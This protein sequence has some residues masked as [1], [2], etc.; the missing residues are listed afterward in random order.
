MVVKVWRRREMQPSGHDQRGH[1]A[2]IV[3]A[4]T[5]VGLGHGFAPA[6][7]LRKAASGLREMRDLS[8]FAILAADIERTFIAAR[9]SKIGWPP[10]NGQGKS[11][12]P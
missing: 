12:P 2:L 3:T 8:H 11:L 1:V 9:V 5:G 7:R 4:R 10:Q 6:S